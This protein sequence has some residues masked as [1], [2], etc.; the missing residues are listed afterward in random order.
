VIV[1]Q[2]RIGPD[3][4]LP[5]PARPGSVTWAGVTQAQVIRRGERRMPFIGCNLPRRNEIA[6]VARPIEMD[7][8]EVLKKNVS[9]TSDLGL[10]PITL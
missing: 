10:S 1:L 2:P 4:I 9:R 5:A 8:L 7:G 3:V 6:V